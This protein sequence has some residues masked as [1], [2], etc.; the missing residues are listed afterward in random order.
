MKPAF[1]PLL[2]LVSQLL[3]AQAPTWQWAR[4]HGGAERE[5]SKAVVT[6]NSGNV[7]ITGSF[8]TSLV[9][10][11]TTNLINVSGTCSPDCSDLFLVKYDPTGNVIWA[12]SAGSNLNDEGLAICTDPIGNIFITGNFQGTSIAF[13]ST[14][15]YNFGPFRTFFI[16]KY[17]SQGNLLWARN[18]ANQSSG[19]GTG[20]A[21]DTLGN[22]VA[23]G[24]F[25]S[26]SIAFGSITL[27]NTN[28]LSTDIFLVKYD[29]AGN[30]MWARKGGG[31]EYDYATAIAS[32]LSGNVFV[33]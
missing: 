27:T 3:Y 8:S 22:V 18:T 9:T 7:Y 26:V 12:R 6:D 20:I 11:G 23:S 30:V 15:L 13:N 28:S 1:V 29:P 19:Y 4:T 31:T 24:W 32:D 33:T 21:C 14:V 5:V 17:D 2:F 25:S 10:F 16:A